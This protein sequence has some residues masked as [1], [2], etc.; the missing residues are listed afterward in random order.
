MRCAQR[1]DRA[2]ECGDVG[3][4]GGDEGRCVARRLQPRDQR[5]GRG[6]VDVDE[7]DARALRGELLDQ[8]GADAGGAT[9]DQ[10]AAVLQ[11]GIAGGVAHDIR[12]RL[13]QVVAVVRSL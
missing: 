9:G 6:R 10:H 3:Q 2:V 8:R 5:L 4:V 12:H 13:L 11:T 1:F 7:A